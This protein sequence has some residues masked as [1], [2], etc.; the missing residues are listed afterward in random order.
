MR[1]VPPIEISAAM[2]T[3]SNVVETA[4][5][6]Y[7]G[8]TT[9]ALGAQVSVASGTTLTCYQSLAGGNTGNAPAS[10]PAW[11]TPIGV[12]YAAYS[13]GTTYAK[14]DIVLDA[15][16]HREYESLSAGNSGNPLTDATKWFD[17][18]PS[19]RWRMFDL[20]RSTGATRP[21]SITVTLTPGKRIDTIALVG[22]VGDSV[23]VSMTVGGTE[24]YSG[25]KSLSKRVSL[26]WRDYF[27]Q[28]FSYRRNVA[29]FDL[30]PYANGVVTIMVTRTGRDVTVGGVIIG[31]SVYLGGTEWSPISD[32]ENF[33][34]VSRDVDG[35]AELVQRRSIPTTQQTIVSTRDNILRLTDLREQLNA[36]PALWSALDDA[37]SA[38]F[39]PLLILGF[40]RRFT[41]TV[42]AENVVRTNLELEEI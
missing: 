15:T 8:G 37:E 23:S 9:Y 20:L 35:N 40:Y 12:T 26:G 7:A 29:F 5:A 16:A 31:Q 39:E 41:I 22:L 4:P 38:F 6:A 14:G 34:E 28:G 3:T 32:A 27:F 10:S 42:E 24:V 13:A 33:S 19:N 30:P 2:L 21:G 17:R 25:Q 11:W 36:V 18:G 1:C